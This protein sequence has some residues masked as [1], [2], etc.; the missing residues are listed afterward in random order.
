MEVDLKM[1]TVWFGTVF[2]V[3]TLQG[4]VATMPD[5]EPIAA[6]VGDYDARLAA[7]YSV[8]GGATIK[9]AD[10]TLLA[11]AL[12][13]EN[14]LGVWAFDSARSVTQLGAFQETGYHPDGVAAWDD[15]TFAVAVE[16]EA[17]VQ[18]WHVEGNEVQKGAELR[19]PVAARDLVVAD[20]DGDGYQDIVLGPYSGTALAV[21]WGRGQF[22]FDIGEPLPSGEAPWHPK[23]VDWNEDGKPDLM[24][25]E[26]DGGH[27]RLALNLGER[28]FDIES[29]RDVDG[30]TPRDLAIGDINRDGRNDVVIA[31]EIGG[32]EVLMHQ[33]GTAYSVQTLPAHELGYV[34]V[35]VLD[36]GTIVLGD[37]GEVVLFRF[38]EGQWQSR[39]LT[40]G[41]MPAPLHVA[42][43][44]NDGKQDLL[45]FHSAS[46]G[47]GIIV[48]YGP[49]WEKAVESG[50]VVK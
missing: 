50:L 32:A 49:L 40:A 10:R 42:D 48:H 19:S 8:W 37:E 9:Q 14:R 1:Q 31:V 44:D 36:D 30:T 28:R 6:E 29:F 13:G 18:F 38:V 5:S 26:L 3:A 22:E 16:G 45:I 12:H 17:L 43:I 35:V 24:W 20:F 15:N 33:E 27:V 25:G 4:C 39:Q 23:V 34:S 7:G 41:S 21:L 46:A 2:I 11:V 47:D